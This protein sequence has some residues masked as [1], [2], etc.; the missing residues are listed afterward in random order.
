MPTRTR[1]AGGDRGIVAVVRRQTSLPRARRPDSARAPARGEPARDVCTAAASQSSGRVRRRRGNCRGAAP[2]VRTASRR[3]WLPGTRTISRSAPLRG[4]D[5]PATHRSATA[6]HT[7]S[8]P[9]P[10]A[11]AQQLERRHRAGRRRSTFRQRCQRFSSRLGPAQHVTTEACPQMQI[12]RGRAC[13]RRCGTVLDRD[14]QSGNQRSELGLDR[15]LRAEI[16][17][18]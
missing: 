17:S 11:L 5:G 12:E 3:L 13:A 18:H 14:P 4:A 1:A 10:Q 2:M 8:S 15:Q 16:R 9:P 7:P 6:R